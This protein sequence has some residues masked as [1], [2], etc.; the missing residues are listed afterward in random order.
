M[1]AEERE[2]VQKS[3]V[4]TTAL[5]GA[6]VA[7]AAE[8]PGGSGVLSDEEKKKAEAAAVKKDADGDAPDTQDAAEQVEVGMPPAEDDAG[9]DD[10]VAK[11]YFIPIIKATDEEQTVTGVVLEPETVDAHGD[12]YD[13]L[14]IRKAAYKFLSQFNKTTKLGFMHKDMKPDFELCE[15]WIAPAD[16]VINGV[17]VKAGS[18]IM[19]VRIL[20]AAKWKLVKDGK[21][22][23]FSIGGMAK[24]KKISQTSGAANGG[25]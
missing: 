18:W 20:S 15:S 19:T 9:N 12:I 6:G 5:S 14:V 22:T 3:V 4:T 7:P 11:K 2:P 1:P 17:L 8:L 10:D 13:A 21:V 16:V 24:V 23:G 25:T